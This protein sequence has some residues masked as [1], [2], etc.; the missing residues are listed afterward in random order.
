MRAET[1]TLQED[2]KQMSQE[3]VAARQ[4]LQEKKAVV[5]ARDALLT[6]RERDTVLQLEAQQRE[7]EEKERRR[8]EKFQA[9]Q[10][11]AE[12][13]RQVLLGRISEME[14]SQTMRFLNFALAEQEKER[15]M[16]VAAEEEAKRIEAEMKERLLEEHRAREAAEADARDAANAAIRIQS[17]IRGNKGRNNNQDVLEALHGSRLK[18]LARKKELR[19]A[20]KLQKRVRIMLAK[21]HLSSLVLVMRERERAA[22]LLQSAARGMHTRRQITEGRAMLAAEMDRAQREAAILKLQT[23]QRKR[24]SAKH[25]GALRRERET[26]LAIEEEMRRMVEMHAA[27]TRIQKTWRTRSAKKST[28]R[29]AAEAATVDIINENNEHSNQ[30][31]A[32]ASRAS[33]NASISTDREGGGGMLDAAG[34]VGCNLTID[35]PSDNDDNISE[36]GGSSIGGSAGWGGSSS[37]ASLSPSS[38]SGLPFSPSRPGTQGSSAMGSGSH[39]LPN[40]GVGGYSHPLGGSSATGMDSVAGSAAGSAAGSVAGS[41][42]GGTSTSRGGTPRTPTSPKFGERRAFDQKKLDAV[43]NMP[44]GESRVELLRAKQQVEG[45]QEMITEVSWRYR[46]AEI[47]IESLQDTQAQNEAHINDLTAQIDSKNT[48]IDLRDDDLSHLRTV[49]GELELNFEEMCRRGEVG[50]MTNEELEQQLTEYKD[51]NFHTL[52]YSRFLEEQLFEARKLQKQIL[53]NNGGG[54]GNNHRGGASSLGDYGNDNANSSNIV[55]T[56]SGKKGGKKRSVVDAPVGGNDNPQ[57]P[58]QQSPSMGRRGR[59]GG[60]YVDEEMESDFG[61]LFKGDGNDS[62]SSGSGRSSSASSAVNTPCTTPNATLPTAKLVTGSSFPPITLASSQNDNDN[63]NDNDSSDSGQPGEAEKKEGKKDRLSNFLLGKE[64][65]KVKAMPLSDILGKLHEC[66]DDDDDDDGDDSSS[67]SDEDEDEDEEAKKLRALEQRRVKEALHAMTVNKME[68]TKADSALDVL[69]TQQRALKEYSYRQE[70]FQKEESERM[71]I[72]ALKKKL[73][74]TE[75]LL[76]KK[77]ELAASLDENVKALEHRIGHYEEEHSARFREFMWVR[78]K[79][80]P[81]AVEMFLEDK[82]T[83]LISKRERKRRNKEHAQTLAAWMQRQAEVSLSD[84]SPFGLLNLL[85]NEVNRDSYFGGA[86]NQLREVV[87]VSFDAKKTLDDAASEI[88]T[89]L[90]DTVAP[91]LAKRLQCR[92]EVQKW[93]DTFFNLCGRDAVSGDKSS[94]MHFE[95]IAQDY[96]KAQQSTHEIISQVRGMALL[97]EQRRY[98]FCYT[99]VLPSF[100]P[101]FLFLF[102][103]VSLFLSRST[104]ACLHSPTPHD[105]CLTIIPHSI[106]QSSIDTILTS[107][108]TLQVRVRGMRPLHFPRHWQAPGAVSFSLYDPRRALVGHGGPRQR[109]QGRV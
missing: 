20:V 57:Y 76:Q 34:C 48:Y 107:L 27:S 1:D 86:K 96:L 50:M 7:H 39:Y 70:E 46:Q 47:T 62:P 2:A 3:L 8:E 79:P 69:M 77:A 25:V 58:Q 42:T 21:K 83:T 109:R 101:S 100:L 106:N 28:V 67:S 84:G 72:L 14:G 89:Y 23:L 97:A 16:R 45:L 11:E 85:L 37:Q 61:T 65:D 9:F 60:L 12:A 49:L 80:H 75:L 52:G 51:R 88:Q 10:L 17:I 56:V 19:A 38:L 55:V 18:M 4:Q 103:I 40:G 102:V 90:D 44:D 93:L 82:L 13:Q 43:R 63:D 35:T 78:E 108:I 30:F 29:Q 24:A 53:E 26:Q 33:T 74:S 6:E 68:H 91:A 87:Q 22:T 66:E 95:M 15:C 31:G 94:S 64:E 81:R 71:V 5:A 92:R 99:I 98:V 104:A 105:M 59:P 41:G 36:G 73:D 54:A 32:K